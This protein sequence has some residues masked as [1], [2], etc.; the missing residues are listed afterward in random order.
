MNFKLGTELHGFTVESVDK[1]EK[2]NQCVYQLKYKKNGASLV[3]LSNKDTNNA[4]GIGFLTCPQD[5][6]GVAHILEHLVLCGSK[7]F[8]VKDPFFS[9]LRRS[10]ANFM[11]AFTAS[12]W[13]MY[14]FSSQNP[15]DFYNL[16][17]VYTDAVF[18][19]LLKEKSFQQEAHRLEQQGAETIAQ[20]VVFNEMK[21]AMSSPMEIMYRRTLNSVFPSITYHHNSG[22]EPV[23]ILDLDLAQLQEFHK[24]HY[25][26]SNAKFF[27]YG[28]FP[29]C[30]YFV[31]RSAPA[32]RSLK[33]K[34]LRCWGGSVF[35]E[36]LG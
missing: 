3:H 21:G 14:P 24:T 9:M 19:P 18:F 25:H 13:T 22:G 7:K 11:N 36:I 33:K 15:K 32:E 6:S 35:Y 4:F 10:L 23:D 16:M 26:P 12:D 29:L 5:S 2:I 8:P 20:G 34:I 27:S 31:S 1:I 28:S 17:D 30:F